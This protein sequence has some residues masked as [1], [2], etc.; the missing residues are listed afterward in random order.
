MKDKIVHQVI[1]IPSDIEIKKFADSE[2]YE[3]P[4]DVKDE[5]SPL[6]VGQVIALRKLSIYDG[7]KWSLSQIKVVDL[8]EKLIKCLMETGFVYR[9][10]AA[11]IIDKYLASKENRH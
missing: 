11:P 6:T 5:K 9:E 2:F 7:A 8:R 10:Q 1:G 4:D 3:I